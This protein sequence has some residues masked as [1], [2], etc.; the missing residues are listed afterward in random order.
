LDAIETAVLLDHQIIPAIIPYRFEDGL[1]ELQEASG[2]IRL[3]YVALGLRV[4]DGK[5]VRSG[6][7]KAPVLEK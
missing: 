5:D 7:R 2:Y 1:P 4:G 6:H 3:C